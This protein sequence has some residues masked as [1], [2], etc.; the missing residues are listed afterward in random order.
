M[1]QLNEHEELLSAWRSLTSA[2]TGEGWRAIAIG[3][4]R[5]RA[6]V[7]FP[8]NEEALM[9]GFN[10]PFSKASDL[11]QGRGFA[12][13]RV[14]EARSGGFDL[15]LGVARKPT[16]SLEMFTLMAADVLAAVNTE[17]KNDEL[18]A[19]YKFLS[20]IKSWQQFMERPRDGRLSDEDELGLF[21]EL[22]V[23]RLLLKTGLSASSVMEYWKGPANGLRDFMTETFDLEVKSTASANHFPARISSLEQLDD[24]SGQTVCLAAFRFSIQ[25]SGTNL[26]ALINTVRNEIGWDG[27][28]AFE[29]SLLLAGYEDAFAAEYTR[30]FVPVD[31]RVFMMTAN[32]PRLSRTMTPLA[33]R[34]AEYELDL[35]LVDAA[36]VELD[37]IILALGGL[38]PL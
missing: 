13:A 15:W 11:P 10:M 2:E 37:D 28:A 14:G 22:S 38:K 24:V 30:S 6:G 1:A 19:Y 20:R 31:E 23:V 9:V 33:I 17:S 26:P 34:S 29:R 12:V 3:S 16:A 8:G 25:D 18:W 5:C 4:G 32:F 21:G 7:K 36:T 27:R 35:D